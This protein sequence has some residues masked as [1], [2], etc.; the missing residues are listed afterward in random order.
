MK[1]ILKEE[2]NSFFIL[3]FRHGVQIDARLGFNR[4][5][6]SIR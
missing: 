5:L 3:L 1:M 6:T 2:R 4:W